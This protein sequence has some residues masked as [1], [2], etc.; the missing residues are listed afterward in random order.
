[1]IALRSRAGVCAAGCC[2]AAASCALFAGLRP[3]TARGDADPASDVLLEQNAFYPYQPRVSGQWQRILNDLLAEA[4]HEHMAVKV[5]IIGAPFDLGAI[6]NFFGH[7]QAYADFLES[8]IS[9]LGPQPLLVVMAAGFGRAHIG[10][11]SA[12]ARVHISATSG[13]DGLTRTAILAVAALARAH[14]HQLAL[15]RL[16]PPPSP[17]GGPPTTA[18]LAL[19]ALTSVGIGLGVVRLRARRRPGQRGPATT[20]RSA[21][22]GSAAHRP[23]LSVEELTARR[24]A[25]RRRRRRRRALLQALS[26]GVL[27]AAILAAVLT[28]SV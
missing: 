6:P 18:I 19:L 7:P 21:P 10:P 2:A 26:A 15:P 27:L 14:G 11:A 1:V 22:S 24:A 9:Y 25:W 17:R 4:A 13:N 16:P 5:A 20:A 8:E 3:A 23:P 28:G 12:L